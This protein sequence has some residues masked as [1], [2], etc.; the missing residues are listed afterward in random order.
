M[1]NPTR[2]VLKGNEVQ[3]TGALQLHI[4]PTMNA[5][6]PAKPESHAQSVQVRI[7]ESNA[8]YAIVEVTCSCGKTTYVRCEYAGASVLPVAAGPAKT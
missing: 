4:D 3:F 5:G 2:H 1:P 6:M 7:A 8:Q